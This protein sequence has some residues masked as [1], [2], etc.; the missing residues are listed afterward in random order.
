MVGGKICQDARGGK[1]DQGN[2]EPKCRLELSSL[3]ERRR[4]DEDGRVRI[5]KCRM[6]ECERES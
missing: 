5:L 1:L 6:N 4:E 3:K 2:L